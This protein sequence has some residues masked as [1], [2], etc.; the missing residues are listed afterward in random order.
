[1][2]K[3]S[4]F[5]HALLYGLSGALVQAGGVVLTPLL[6]RCL[7]MADFGAL[8]VVGRCAELAGMLL[9][10]GGLRQGLLTFHQQSKSDLERQRVFRA[11][12][13]LLL[14]V[15]LLGGAV[16]MVVAGPISPFSAPATGRRS[17]PTCCAWPCWRFCSNR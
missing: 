14:G 11:T 13:V 10:I 5:R 2:E 9:L 1:M 4:F 15:C 12:M 8:E 16:A 17:I 3:Q 6:T 7:S